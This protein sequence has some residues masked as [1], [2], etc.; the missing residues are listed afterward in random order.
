MKEGVEY[1]TCSAIHFDDGKKHANQPFNIKTGIVAC[2][3]RHHNCFY[4]LYMMHQR[5]FL[6][7]TWYDLS[8][9]KKCIQGFLTSKNRFVDRKEATSIAYNAKQVATHETKLYSEDL[10]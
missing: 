9:K 7:W 5:R 4:I 1:I 3:L 10:W 6:F 2:G 8:Y